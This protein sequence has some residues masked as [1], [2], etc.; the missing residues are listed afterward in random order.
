M[1][2]WKP[3]EKLVIHYT[4]DLHSAFEQMPKIA[5]AFRERAAYH[6]DAHL[7]RLD[8]GDHMD[9]MR[10]ETEGTHGA[11]NIAVMNETGYDFVVLGNNEGLTFTVDL[12]REMYVPHAQFEVIGSNITEPRGVQALTPDWMVPY[13][14]IDKGSLRIG[15]IGVT[16][17]YNDFY[18]LLGWYI[19][20]PLETVNELSEWLRP[21]VDVLIVMSHLGLGNDEKIAR[22]IPGIDLIIGGHTHHLLEQPLFIEETCICAA[23]KLGYH[24]GEIVFSFPPEPLPDRT[25]RRSYDIEARVIDVRNYQDDARVFEIWHD[26]RKNGIQQMQQTVAHLAQPL[27]LHWHQESPMGNLLAAAIRSWVNAEIGLVNAGQFLFE[28]PAGP[29]TKERLLELCPSPI[30][31]CLVELSGAQIRLA[32]EQSLLPEFSRKEIFGFG[33]RGKTLGTL[34][35]DGLLVT[36]KR[37]APAGCKV[38]NIMC[39]GEPFDDERMYRVGTID[40]FTFGIGYLS[41]RD[42]MSKRFYLPEFIRDVFGHALN[43]PQMMAAAQNAERFRSI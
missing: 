22:A 2:Q 10:V 6:H 13:K 39:N 16:A 7:L 34:C 35:V 41:L 31:P 27:A 8:I 23:G 32:L 40:M 17:M 15:I 11:A 37:D 3:A 12:L 42:S 4:N 9:R 14:I 43:D 5:S 38:V 36:V 18:S 1:T 20:D 29:L 26:F 21:Q 28:L 25:L 33:F 30:N 19:V 24:V